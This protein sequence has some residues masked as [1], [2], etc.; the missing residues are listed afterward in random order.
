MFLAIPYREQIEVKREN[1][2]WLSIL[3]GFLR[4]RSLIFYIIYG[5]K[6]KSWNFMNSKCCLQKHWG[7]KPWK[8]ILSIFCDDVIMMW[9]FWNYFNVFLLQSIWTYSVKV[10]SPSHV[11]VKNSSSSKSKFLFFP[12]IFF[13]FY[14]F[15][16]LLTF[17]S[18]LFQINLSIFPFFIILAFQKYI[19]I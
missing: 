14:I 13:V 2:C 5:Y 4:F 12:L 7:K 9:N 19:V 17:A 10:W 16:K 11:L 8:F 3:F 6:H 18:F 15:E 1:L